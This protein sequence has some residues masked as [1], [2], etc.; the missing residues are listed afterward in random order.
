MPLLK[1]TL[2]EELLYERNKQFS[3]EAIL[4]EVKHL[5]QQNEIEREAIKQQL[6]Q[7]SSTKNSFNSEFIEIDRVF[8]IDQIK[9]ICIDFRL[10]FLDS[11][12]FKNEIPEEAVSKIRML[13]KQH[14]SKFGNFKIAAPSKL[15]HLE[16][17]DDPLLFVPISDG[18]Y[19]LVHKWGKDLNPFRKWM[20]MPF[21]NLSNFML[22]LLAASILLTMA[23][24]PHAFGKAE[25]SIVRIVS[26]LFIFKSLVAIALYCCFWKGKNLNSEIWNSSYYNN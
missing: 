16:S 15:F 23:I 6:Y 18:Y 9:K 11:A 22:S 13:E 12:S 17:Y 3:E 8:H 24:P 21:K 14:N 2:V 20:M 5:L 19:Y 7:K 25:E 4:Q 1:K 26:F 10:R